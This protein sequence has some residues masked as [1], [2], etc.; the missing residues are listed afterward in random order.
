MTRKGKAHGAEGA[1][2]PPELTPHER[3]VLEESAREVSIRA[4]GQVR[5]ITKGDAAFMKHMQVALE[6]SPHAL[7]RVTQQ[8]N[9]AQRAEQQ[10][11]ESDIEFG[12]Q[13]K[14]YQR[15]QLN[16]AIARGDNPDTVLPHPDDIEVSFGVGFRVN[17]PINRDELESIQRICA[18]RDLMLMQ[19]V[20]EDRLGSEEHDMADG[21]AA[22][23]YGS[24][25]LVMA[26]FMNH[27]LPDRFHLSDVQMIIQ[28]QQHERV[29]KRE[30]LK[31]THR[32]W[33]AIGR[34]KPRGA[35][36]AVLETLKSRMEQ[37]W[38]C[39]DRLKHQTATG[40]LPSEHELADR[41][42]RMSRQTDWA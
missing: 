38:P 2:R 20:L 10:R 23:T 26:H 32:A 13:L 1:T 25:P 7:G 3:F 8:I 21:D 5:R 40:T 12:R 18:H 41:I 30:L 36:M 4:D 34:P 42:R 28:M 16:R 29:T 6:G 14:V 31:A 11:I 33:R 39:V 19:A 15:K 22:G 17:G 35:R 27:G 37:L 9:A 24:T